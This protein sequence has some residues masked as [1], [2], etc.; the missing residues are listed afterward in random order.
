MAKKTKKMQRGGRSEA[1]HMASGQPIQWQSGATGQRRK[2]DYMSH[3]APKV[4]RKQMR[5]QAAAGGPGR[6]ATSGIGIKAGGTVKKMQGGGVTSVRGR[7]GPN[8]SPRV[9]VLGTGAAAAHQR[10]RAGGTHASELARQQG[11]G[12]QRTRSTGGARG[13][14]G[15]PPGF[16]GGG[17]VSYND[18]IRSKG[19]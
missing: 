4:A 17:T 3:V 2:A 5:R 10:A 7:G 14:R 18:L 19:W 16:S 9:N 13:A 6:G 11:A 12:S 8:V 1:T 15:G